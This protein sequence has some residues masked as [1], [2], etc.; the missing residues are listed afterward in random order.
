MYEQIC[1]WD[2]LMRAYWDAGQKMLQDPEFRKAMATLGTD[3]TPWFS[4][5]GYSKQ[6]QT[7]MVMKSEAVDW[8]RTTM[9]EYGVVL[10]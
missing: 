8:L 2:N 1:A 5:E 7:N 6:F 9:A 4:G 3:K 10:E